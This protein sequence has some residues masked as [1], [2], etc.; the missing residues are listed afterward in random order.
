MSGTPQ[1]KTQGILC[2]VKFWHDKGHPVMVILP[3]YCFNEMEVEKRRSMK[4]T[5]ADEKT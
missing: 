1:F 5:V 2:S 4:L 3:D